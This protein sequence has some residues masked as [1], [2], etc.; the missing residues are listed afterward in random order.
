MHPFCILN[1]WAAAGRFDVDFNRSFN[2]NFTFAY[3][4]RS[5]AVRLDRFD[6]FIRSGERFLVSKHDF[7]QFLVMHTIIPSISAGQHWITYDQNDSPA[8]HEIVVIFHDTILLWE[9][10]HVLVSFTFGSYIAALCRTSN[11]YWVLVV[12]SAGGCEVDS[13]ASLSNSIHAYWPKLSALSW[14]FAIVQ[15]VVTKF[16]QPCVGIYRYNSFEHGE[17]CVTGRAQ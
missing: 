3:F 11:K 2:A 6:G 10:A 5:D 1:G 15:A 8:T 9:V 4:L 12:D 17:I 7:Y 14:L 13:S 16:W